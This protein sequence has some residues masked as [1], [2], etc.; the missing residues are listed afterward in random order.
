[1]FQWLKRKPPTAAQMAD[2]LRAMTSAAITDVKAKWIQFDSDIHTKADVPLSSKMGIF[3]EAIPIFL[4]KKY[5][6]IFLGTSEMFWLTVFTAILESG[7]HSKDKVNAA[8]AELKKT[9]GP[10]D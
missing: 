9:Y 6:H 8:I 7:T 4:K 1:M 2:D 10:S 5:P 3:I